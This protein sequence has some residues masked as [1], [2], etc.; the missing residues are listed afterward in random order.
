MQVAARLLIPITVCAFCTI[1]GPD[2]SRICRLACD[3][4][5]VTLFICGNTSNS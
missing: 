1:S 2:D 5:Q 3:A 4:V